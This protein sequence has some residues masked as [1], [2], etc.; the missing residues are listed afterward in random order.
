MKYL[1]YV[2]AILA[3]SLVVVWL[4]ARAHGNMQ[5]VRAQYA[6]AVRCYAVGQEPRN[7]HAKNK[8]YFE[9]FEECDLT[10]GHAL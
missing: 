6:G 8:H 1:Y 2:L 5:W 10:I 3:L 9:S 7:M 4:S